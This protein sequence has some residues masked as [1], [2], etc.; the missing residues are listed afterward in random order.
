MYF[1]RVSRIIII[2]TRIGLAS[3]KQLFRKSNLH[4][5]TIA[6]RSPFSSHQPIT[7]TVQHFRDLYMY[8]SVYSILCMAY[9]LVGLPKSPFL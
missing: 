7:E 3:I 4:S 9:T 8:K 5:A 2:Q 1:M 6:D